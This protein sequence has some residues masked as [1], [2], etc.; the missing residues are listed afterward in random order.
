MNMKLGTINNF[1]K[2]LKVV[3]TSA[4]FPDDVIKIGIFEGFTGGLGK[5]F[6]VDSVF[7]A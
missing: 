6:T 1:H 4:Y 5:I 2:N 3:M 7:V